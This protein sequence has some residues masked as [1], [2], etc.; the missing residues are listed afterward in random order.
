[1]G[2]VLRYR[3]PLSL[4]DRERSLHLVLIMQTSEVEF[5]M[6][7]QKSAL[8]STFVVGSEV[9]VA[10][11]PQAPFRGEWMSRRQLAQRWLG[12]LSIRRQPG[13]GVLKDQ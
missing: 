8:L 5:L 11:R 12:R 6:N 4:R 9:I 10:P 13:R 2:L 1:M 7:L 3:P